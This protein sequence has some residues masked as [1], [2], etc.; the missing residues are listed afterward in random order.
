M[1]KLSDYF[2]PSQVAGY[3][4]TGANFLSQYFANQ[5][6]I[7]LAERANQWSIDQW[8]REN[9]YNLPSNQVQRLQDAGINPGILYGQGGL[10]NESAP[11]PS[12]TPGSGV[13][14]YIMDPLAMAQVGLI[15]AQK[16]KAEAEATGIMSE[17]PEKLRQY[18]QQ[19]KES[20]ARISELNQTVNNL[21]QQLL[22]MQE[23]QR[24]TAEKRISESFYRTLSLRQFEETCRKNTA[25]INKM[26]K[27]M[28]LMDKQGKKLVAETADVQAATN[29]KVQEYKYLAAAN[30][31]RLLGLQLDNKL[32]G[33]TAVLYGDQH[34]LNLDQHR[35]NGLQEKLLGFD[36][37]NGRVVAN[38][39]AQWLND[40]SAPGL[41]GFMTRS[42]DGLVG[43]MQMLLQPLHGIISIK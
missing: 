5:A 29:L 24:Y 1:A 10:M 3:V 7:G 18:E 37:T 41:N 42:L 33:L 25:E 8:N 27:E 26:G 34:T 28:E 40:T 12:V 16:D 23:D 15:D 38:R 19:R 35:L 17:L 20:D 14:P 13:R 32:K 30:S 9:Q 11:S 43:A 21:Q 6:N 36:V 39:N 22:N 2:G 31:Y 4:T